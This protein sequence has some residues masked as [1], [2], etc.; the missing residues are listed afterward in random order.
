MKNK[1]TNN[2]KRFFKQFKKQPK[3]RNI[4]IANMTKNIKIFCSHVYIRP[5]CTKY[6]FA[7]KSH[8]KSA[9]YL[10]IGIINFDLCYATA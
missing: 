10:S 3:I 6:K 4:V 1:Q 8:L 9:L 7:R 2:K 5:I